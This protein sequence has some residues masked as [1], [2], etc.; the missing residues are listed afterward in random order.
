MAV[1]SSLFVFE[2]N[3]GQ[4]RFHVAS[5]RLP[6]RPPGERDG[7]GGIAVLGPV[8]VI[9]DDGAP[10]P[11]GSQ[12]QVL[13]LAVLVSRLGK[14]VSADE[15]VEALWADKLPD[16]PMAALQSQVFRLRRRLAGVS[17][18]LDND[19]LGYRLAGDREGVDAAR[20]ED[21]VAEARHRSSEPEVAVGLL[22]DALGLWR[23]GAYL[24]VADHAAVLAEANRLEELRADAAELRAALLLE[25][26]AAGDA[27]RAMESLMDEHPFRERPVAIRMRA[28]AREGR[29]AEALGLF[30]AFRRTLG[31]ELG[32]E[33]SP[34]LCMLEGEILR[35]DLP[36]AP[37]IGLPGNSLVGR[38]VELADLASRLGVGRLVTLTG[39]GGI[40]KTRLALHAAARAAERYPDGVWL[41]EL[42]DVGAVD[43]VA[44]AVASAFHVER[45]AEHTDAERVVQF[46]RSRRALLV[47]DNCEH[48]LDGAR[49]L[50]AAILAHAPDVDVVATS[51]RRLGVE[52]ERVVPVNSLAVADWDDPDSP[53]AVLFVDR[54]QAVRPDFTLTDDNTAAV[55]ALC[56]CL[57]GLPLA[58]ELAAARTVTRTPAEILAEV[59][60]RID[61]L[62]DPFRS[63]ERHRSIEAVVGWSY[64]R[65]G[66]VEQHLFSTV[67][68][69]AGG[70]TAEAAA[71]VAETGRD[72]VVAALTALVEHSLVA[73]HDSGATTRFSLL[74]PI[75]HYAEARLADNGERD[76]ARAR[77]AAW[78]A[79]WIQTAD[80]GLRGAEEAH[81]AETVA[82]ELANLR[83][84]HRW[85]LDHDPDTA[86]RITGAMF[87]Y[88][89]WYGA[90]EA[91]EWAATT[92][93]RVRDETTPWLAAAYA[94]AALGACRRGDMSEA[95]A[96]AGRGIAAA[97]SEPT[98]AR[99][100]WEALSS[101][102][103]MT[104]NYERTLACQQHALDLARL[105]G[106]ITQQ[107]REHGA[108]AVALGYLGQLDNADGE[109]TTA[110]TLAATARNPT[111]QAFCD[112]VG[113]EIRI[114]T[115]PAKALPLLERARDIG[116]LVGNRYL[117]AIA[118]VS[119]VSCAAR[120]G[121]PAQAVGGY[122][123]LLDYFDRTGSRAQQWTT[124]RTLIETLTRLGRD[125]DAAILHGALSAS[126]SA[127]PL[128]G[129]DAIRM[130]DAVTTLG[131][132]LGQDRFQQ[133][134][135]HGA[136]LDDDAAIAYARRCTTND[137]TAG[138]DNLTR[139]ERSS[140]P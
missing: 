67:S 47:F 122:T 95:R 29:H 119:A 5:T 31:E 70:F 12:R 132:R 77:H 135:A 41:C 133:L 1:P 36:P 102:E 84:A 6:G 106:D 109:L 75:R 39:P 66:P 140:V 34:E 97:A 19:G 20:F 124:I 138:N 134:S 80:A 100:A 85:S 50:I 43:A 118:G 7:M 125:E 113:G 46:L 81:W 2:G 110:T 9:G 28:L 37:R 87:W 121:N 54:A 17:V 111:V 15:L 91:F 92:V 114:D 18:Q 65:L 123:E 79:G 48:V 98:A 99:F 131:A 82:A 62:V 25:L 96:L 139:P 49:D 120:I 30:D 83:T 53:A 24:E 11:V 63:K 108:R 52:G 26:G 10:V 64:D 8:R 69:F 117:S 107:A 101:A 76:H 38:E 61:E 57:D 89:C 90:S 72:E 27:A 127:L 32:L 40:G 22:D 137:R 42:A 14:V 74:E 116:R 105:A 60:E 126:L 78:A 35:H 21:L 103:M 56:R 59:A 44:P 112:Y 129:A 88:A 115:D 3:N 45:D 104:G 71:S 130:H 23:G 4:V 58:L 73:A 13:L 128:I 136:A 86:M 51:R 93:A 68:V 94:T 55:C 33:P 16:H